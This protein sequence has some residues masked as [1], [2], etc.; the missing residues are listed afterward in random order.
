MNYNIFLSIGFS[1][2][3]LAFELVIIFLYS[4]KKI[5]RNI[6]NTLFITLLVLT[7]LLITSEII[8]VL[9]LAKNNTITFTARFFSRLYLN[10]MIAWLYLFM[11]YISVLRTKRY[12]DPTLKHE[13]RKKYAYIIG[14]FLIASLI[15]SNLLGIEFYDYTDHI[16]NFTGD[17][18]YVAFASAGVVIFLMVYGFIFNSDIKTYQ[19][20][21]IIYCVGLIVL[22][23]LLQF[24]IPNA[25]YNIQNFQ[26]TLMLLTLYFTIESQDTKLLDE[27]EKSK[28]EAE[29]ANQDQTKFLTSMSHEIRTPMNTIMGFSDAMLREQDLTK[30]T[31]TSDTNNIHI[32]A[33][34][35]LELINNILD[36][37][38]IE[39][40]KE[41]LVEKEYDLEDLFIEI[42]N[43][44]SNKIDR[45]K[46]EFI[47]K[48]DTTLAK[49]YLGDYTKISK[50]VLN[51]LS[52]ISYYI[53][54]GS[55]IFDVHKLQIE[56]K[57]MIEFNIL[58]VGSN[59]EKEEFEKYYKDF[60]HIGN[61]VNDV[62]LGIN[63][64]KMYSEMLGGN[65]ELKFNE[66]DDLNYIVRVE[67]QIVDPNPIGD[68]SYLFS[69]IN[70]ENRILDLSNKNILVVDD[71]QININLLK[72]LLKDYKVNIDSVTS[73]MEALDIVKNKKY[74]L[75]FLD[76]MMP[77]MDGIETIHKLK[78][79]K[80]NL[81]PVIALTA[82]SYTGIKEMYIG[83]GFKDYLAK[84]INRNELNKLLNEIFSS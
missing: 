66:N 73:G 76:H 20:I 35:L 80:Q 31:I 53:K 48:I 30:E 3:A 69:V 39:S 34:S 64:S 61:D 12:T 18:P 84:P 77:V 62:V 54:N 43:Y 60:E 42:N 72:R 10:Y 2:C 81:C 21:P 11:F 27:H 14:G 65:L 51:V 23:T 45:S 17:A 24:M 83:E 67:E 70:S 7:S 41:T 55:I 33:V 5:F 32:A 44:I 28:A 79:I 38:R 56:N 6:E 29:K 9:A 63:V 57:N 36:L 71:N 78:D 16:Y 74:D 1:V 59:M 58:A 15:V 8:Y 37:S 49:K 50:I 52:N 22:S 19:R 13:K 4:N 40:G 26:F 68:I 47:P 75:I 82:N 46:I 25:D